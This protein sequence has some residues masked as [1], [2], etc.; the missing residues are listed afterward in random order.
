MFKLALVRDTTFH[1]KSVERFANSK[2]SLEYGF[3]RRNMTTNITATLS[4]SK[5]QE[6]GFGKLTMTIRNDC[7]PELV[8]GSRAWIRQAHHDNQILNYLP[9]LPYPPAPLLVSLSSVVV[10][11]M[12][13]SCLAITICAIL[14]PDFISKSSV[15][16]FISNTFTSP[17]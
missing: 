15:P 13:V 9:V 7:Q 14:S 3:D 1:L 6:H 11:Q 16:K 4:L 12:A 17:R 2:D 8:E 5:G 10:S